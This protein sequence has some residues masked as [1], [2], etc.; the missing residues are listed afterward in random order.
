MCDDRFWVVRW[1]FF[2]A[3]KGATGQISLRSTD[4]S[5]GNTLLE[6]L[7]DIFQE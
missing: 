5:Q 6:I 4:P 3:E 2:L 1:D 7:S